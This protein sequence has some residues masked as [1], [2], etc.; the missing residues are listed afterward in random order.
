M[1]TLRAKGC[2]TVGDAIDNDDS[3][4]NSNNNTDR[5]KAA[6]EAELAADSDPLSGFLPAASIPPTP[7]TLLTFQGRLDRTLGGPGI[8]LGSTM[9]E[10]AIQITVGTNSLNFSEV[11][12][13]AGAGKTQL[14]L[15]LCA[16]VQVPVCLG[17]LG[18]EAVFIDAE[19]DFKGERMAQVVTATKEDV[20]A[21]IESQA[22]QQTEGYATRRGSQCS[23]NRQHRKMHRI[24][25][26]LSRSLRTP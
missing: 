26:G 1:A 3:N 12:G 19:G 22:M 4:S 14:C 20:E 17:G 21:A 8:P 9:G 6:I 5:W 15:H 24:C 2:N 13:K 16:S 23:F 25:A 7:Q 11:A 10:T 18:G